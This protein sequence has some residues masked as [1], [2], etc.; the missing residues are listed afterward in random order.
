METAQIY[1]SVM[2]AQTD[3]E[4]TRRQANAFKRGN[5]IKL[6]MTDGVILKKDNAFKL[7]DAK[8]DKLRKVADAIKDNTEKVL[9][10]NGLTTRATTNLNKALKEEKT[11]I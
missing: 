7:T 8:G 11:T 2:I 9:F 6:Y 4:A 10:C 5:A 1:K 3:N